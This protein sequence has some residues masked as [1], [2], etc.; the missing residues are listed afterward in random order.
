[1]SE[2]IKANLWNVIGPLAVAVMFYAYNQNVKASIREELTRYVTQGEFKSY[3]D[4]D[5]KMMA[6]RLRNLEEKIDLLLKS[7]GIAP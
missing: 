6:L 5:E 1:M 7:K 4:N 3:Q 2:R